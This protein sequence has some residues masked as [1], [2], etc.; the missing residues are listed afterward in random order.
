MADEFIELYKREGDNI[1]RFFLVRVSDREKAVDLTQ[2]TFMRFWDASTKGDKDSIKYPKSFLFRIAKNLII[3]WY[4]KNKPVSLDKILEDE[5]S[6]NYALLI[7]KDSVDLENAEEARFVLERIK[8]LE[9][10]YQEA[11]Y[12]R[13]VEDLKPQE[14]AEV[15]GKSV[16]VVSV[17]INR[18][19]EKLRELTGIGKINKKNG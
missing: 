2:D 19:I 6:I 1:F 15:L 17:R 16:N 7:D 3:D 18:G 8:D 4:R 9:P 13:F 12:L 10:I 11:V 5:D 14:I